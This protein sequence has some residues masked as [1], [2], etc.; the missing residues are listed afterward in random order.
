MTKPKWEPPD[1]IERVDVVRD[2]EQVVAMPDISIRQT[3]YFSHPRPRF[4]W[5]LGIVTYQPEN[6]RRIPF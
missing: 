4:G 1:F 3:E 6:E 2:S 5:D